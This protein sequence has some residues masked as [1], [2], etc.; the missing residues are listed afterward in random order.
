MAVSLIAVI[1]LFIIVFLAVRNPS[2]N[3]VRLAYLYAVCFASLLTMIIG[4]ARAADGLFGIVYP[5]P[6][7]DTRIQAVPAPGAG[8]GDISPSRDTYRYDPEI[9]AKKERYNQVRQV[10]ENLI[11]LLVVLPVYIYHQRKI[12][13]ENSPAPG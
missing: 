13:N 2:P 11:M 7:A 9:E 1:I 4:F 6:P 5:P 8:P 3:S 10:A 12:K